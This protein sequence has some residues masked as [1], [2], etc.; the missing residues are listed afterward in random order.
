MRCSGWS[1]LAIWV[2]SALFLVDPAAAHVVPS[3]GFIEGGSRESISL[4]V[5]N[6][7]DEPM[8]AFSVAVPNDFVIIH[9]HQA[10][11]WVSEGDDSTANW[12]GGSLDPGDE[13]EFG[14]ELEAPTGAGAATLRATQRYPSGDVVQ[15]PVELTV[16]PATETPS[17]NLGWA[18]LTAGIGLF[19]IGGIA[20]L[21]WRRRAP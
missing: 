1:S 13:E 5:P 17:A 9:A 19:V 4:T 3:P 6:E 2:C 21:A 15:W 8:T 12:T 11:G 14:L 20:V 10:D 7:R 18:V 16:L